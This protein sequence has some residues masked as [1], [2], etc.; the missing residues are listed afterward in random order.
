M[1]CTDTG[2]PPPTGTSPTIMRRVLL[3]GKGV[4]WTSGIPR[5][6]ALTG[7]LSPSRPLARTAPAATG[8]GAGLAPRPVAPAFPRQAKETG[9]IMSA[10]M[11]MTLMATSTPPTAHVSGTMR[12]VSAGPG[13]AFPRA[14]A[15]APRAHS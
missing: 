13:S 1:D 5:L 6:I 4:V 14:R 12:A 11:R 2:A 9:L 10:A 3:R 8:G 7:P 15:S